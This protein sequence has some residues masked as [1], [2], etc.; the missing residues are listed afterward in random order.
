MTAATTTVRSRPLSSAL[1]STDPSKCTEVETV[2][3]VRQTD[4]DPG[5]S[6]EEA[7]AKCRENADEA[8]ADSVD[9][10]EIEVDGDSATANA[11]VT[12]SFFNGQTLDLALVKQGDQWKLDEFRGFAEIDR[13]G[14]ISGIQEGLQEE[15][16]ST[17][18]V[19]CV[20]KQ[21]EAQS[22]EQLE[23]AFLGND[24][25]AEDMIFEPCA[26]FFKE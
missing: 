24:P 25:Q 13:D 14:L 17:E 19:D 22:D 9:V 10:S 5:D 3:F 18:A 7:L 2:N 21:L 12:G 11:K 8:P 23:A 20:T 15:R 6:A 1:P 26:K 4:A 16:G